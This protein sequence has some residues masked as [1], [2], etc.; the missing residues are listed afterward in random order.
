VIAVRVVVGLI[1]LSV[2]VLTVLSAIRTT[3]LP[4]GVPARLARGVFVITGVG[5]GLWAGRAA[6]YSR[7][8][9][10]FASYG[11]VS[12]LLT[13]QVWL[14]SAYLGFAAVQ[15]ATMR[16]RT[17]RGAFS[18]SGS[19]LF[20]LGFDVPHGAL[21]TAVV[22]G[23]ASTG[24]L[25]V[26]LLISYLPAIYASFSRREAM[27]TKMEVRAGSPPNAVDMLKRAWRLAKFERLTTAWVE[28]ETWFVD[29]EETH[30]SFP[31]LVFFRSPQPDHGWVTTAGAVLDSASILSSSIDAPRNID[32][33]LC[34]RSGYLSLRRIAAY[35]G[36]TYD[37]EPAYDGPISVTRWE[38]DAALK[39][40]EEAGVPLRADRDQAWRDFRGWRVNYDRVL[41]GLAGLTLSPY[42][43]WSSDRSLPDGPARLRFLVRL[44]GAPNAPAEPVG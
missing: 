31:S 10:I 1:G 12:L 28:A 23:E 9:R 42:A 15:W 33:E 35:F 26:T 11:P 14:G 13:L 36:L 8:D 30:T 39:E 20:T 29:I 18:D 32:A 38:F 16:H 37:V 44:G 40:L 7:R 22:F 27:V 43:P 21:Q 34:I 17:V 41:V 24:L 5:F 19:A 3:V 6:D 4:R 25:V 2:V